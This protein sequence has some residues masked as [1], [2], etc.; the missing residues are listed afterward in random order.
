MLETLY[1]IIELDSSIKK[2]R[3]TRSYSDFIDAGFI[4]H[5]QPMPVQTIKKLKH[6]EIPAKEE[7]IL[8]SAKPSKSKEYKDSENIKH[9]ARLRLDFDEREANEQY[10]TGNCST[11]T[12]KEEYITNSRYRDLERRSQDRIM[13]Y[14]YRVCGEEIIHEEEDKPEWI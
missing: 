7:T 10:Y 12:N 11:W 5:D 2:P 14:M 6:P 4:F 13:E 8:I 9:T 1:G 3:K